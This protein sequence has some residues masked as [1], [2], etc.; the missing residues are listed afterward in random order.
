MTEQNRTE[1]DAAASIGSTLA[2]AEYIDGI[3]YVVVP[4]GY[5]VNCLESFLAAPQRTKGHTT[6]NDARS[7]IAFIKLN[8]LG[9]GLDAV[10][11]GNYEK[12]QFKA[13]FNH[14]TLLEPG[15]GDHTASYAC[16]KSLEWLAWT[17]LDKRRMTQVEFA[18]FIENNLPNIANPPGAEMLEI[19]R[20]LEAKKQVSF[21]SGIRLS[22][23]QHQLSYQEE[24][25][26]TAAKGQLNIPEIFTIGIPVFHGGIVYAVDARLRYRIHDG[27]KMQMWYELVRPH[28]ILE[29][30]FNG[31][32]K[33]IAE[34]TGIDI[35]NGAV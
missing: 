18:E 25:S 23:G 30:A 29:D 13:I 26:G 6:L 1:V 20:S 10:I 14:G 12:S 31:L 35:L 17:G 22:N 24:I 3:P 28:V 33:G 4:S 27:G 16:P 5:Q 15:W 19:S 8:M 34:G 2:E 7:F 11:Y 21:A 32:W 9:S